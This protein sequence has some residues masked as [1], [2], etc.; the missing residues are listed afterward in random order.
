MTPFG[1]LAQ[2]NLGTCAATTAG[3]K[4]S[5]SA[6]VFTASATATGVMAPLVIH[7]TATRQDSAPSQV[8][9]AYSGHTCIALSAPSMEGPGFSPPTS[10]TKNKALAVLFEWTIA[11]DLGSMEHFT[12][13]VFEFSSTYAVFFGRCLVAKQT[14]MQ[15]ANWRG[16]SVRKHGT[17]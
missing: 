7:T 8:H 3:L 15:H 10:T 14:Y 17:V 9:V 13:G 4:T 5:V 6:Q 11:L 2:V 1:S 12:S 16:Q